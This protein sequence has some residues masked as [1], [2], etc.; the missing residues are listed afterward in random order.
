MRKPRAPGRDRS[1]QTGFRKSR[2]QRRAHEL[3]WRVRGINGPALPSGSHGHDYM[4]QYTA[5]SRPTP[6]T[7]ASPRVNQEREVRGRTKEARVS[8]AGLLRAFTM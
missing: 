8:A 3:V 1:P 4:T 2:K 5:C 6:Q 7:E